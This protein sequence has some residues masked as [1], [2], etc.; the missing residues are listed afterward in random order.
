MRSQRCV[1]GIDVGGTTIKARLEDE[2]GALLASRRVATPR[3]DPSAQRLAEAIARLATEAVGGGRLDAVGLVVPGIVDV[4]A[5]RSVLAVNLG[6]R[7]VPVVDRVRAALSTA[8]LDAPI[9]FGQDV[10]A[11]ALAESHGVGG[12]GAGPVVFLPIG[13]GLAAAVI[14]GGDILFPDGWSGEIGQLRLKH[15]PFHGQR[16][17]EVASASAFATAAGASDAREAVGR[18]DAGDPAAVAAFAATVAALAEVIVWSCAVLGGRRVVIGGGL[19]EAG[20]RLLGPL[21]AAVSDCLGGLPAIDVRRARHGD[22]AG[23]IGAA[24]LARRLLDRSAP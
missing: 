21:R 2:T 11:G 8:S 9:A 13:T 24:I 23:A 10:R 4:A 3:D 17:E 15:P 6:W 16:V 20:D 19:A 14:D 1:L 22:E 18:L 12:P 7:D 5:G